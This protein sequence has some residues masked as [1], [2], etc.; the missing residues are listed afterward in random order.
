[1]KRGWFFT[2]WNKRAE[3]G[4]YFRKS[5]ILVLLITS[6]PSAFIAISNYVIGTGQI[7]KE[8][9]KSHQMKFEQFSKMMDKQFDQ[10]ALVM[11]RWST[12]PLYGVY[13]D[14]L[15]FIDH[16][17]QMHG[18][19][20]SLQVVGGSNLLI[21]EAH[22]YL[23][24]Q[25]AV[26]TADG[27]EYL[28]Q[29]HNEPYLSLLK[30]KEGLFLAYGLPV[31]AIRQKVLPVSVI[32][33]LPWHSKEPFGAFVLNLN[34][35]EMNQ[36][37]TQINSDEKGTAFLLR[38]SGEWVITPDKPAQ[39]LAVQL[40]DRV[41]SFKEAAGS[42]P[43]QWDG[44]TYIVSFGEVTRAEWLYVAAS[45]LSELTKPVLLTSRLILAS[46]LLGIAAALLLAWF[47]S[48]KLYQPIGRLVA[49]FG[50]DKT[51]QVDNVKHEIEF[52]EQQWGRLTHESRSLQERL[53]QSVPSLREG[54][55]L[56]LVQGHLYAF[57]ENSLKD[58]MEQLGWE[59]RGKLFSILLIQLSGLNEEAVR[60]KE[61]DRQLLTFAAA[62]IA[63]ELSGRSSNRTTHAINF[64]DLSVGLLC[65]YSGDQNTEKIR[66]ELNLLSQELI[67]HLGKM[68]GVHVTV[69]V[70][71]LTG[72][73]GTI[74]ELFDQ[75]RQAVRYRDLQEH[76]QVI[77]MEE[78]IP[79][80]REAQY[81]FA[82]EK[83]FLHVMRLG[84]KEEAYKQF[85]EFMMEV[86]RFADREIMVQ[87]S[88]LQ[89]MGS[90]RH[91]LIELGFT[92]H[93]LFT[94]GSP[95]EELIGIREPAAMEKWF[96]QKMMDP[97]LDEFHKAQNVR[98]RQLIEQVAEMLN[99]HYTEDISLEQCAEAFSTS[100]YTL[101]RA[102]KQVLGVNYVDYIMK[103]RMEKAKELLT[104]TQLKINE[105]AERVGYQ[106]SYFNKIFKGMAGMT[107]T[108]Y[109]EQFRG[110]ENR[111]I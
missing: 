84:L 41:M 68:L 65:M 11:S 56:Q 30:Q 7:E 103:L 72:E 55:L 8:V 74:P 98:S 85:S 53:Q 49:L 96:K 75:A 80:S 111:N 70:C 89:L 51:E 26:I 64:Q 94:E 47:A 58:R 95:Y 86:Q 50:S 52:I 60:F 78:F 23:N 76:H 91:M 21:D 63:E 97:Y 37:L 105:I 44:E 59:V 106:H 109:R 101:S 92:N 15:T 28:Q 69:I 17:D 71:R 107:P 100:P 18:I 48:R 6:I 88:V 31:S 10:I 36:M 38:K 102:M 1:M 42:F 24:R 54:F 3:K 90:V 19:M 66:H 110:Q 35:A 33:K 5:L 46:S 27:I 99:M 93:P 39:E 57:D 67:T 4:D 12:N 34:R 77:D 79:R 43:Y 108:Q 29:D 81:P 16:I 87:Q 73:A 20:Q 22:L 14:S 45:P 2:G 9:F 62:N 25:K 83:E 104:T 61:D 82:L 13:L 32:Y 40:R